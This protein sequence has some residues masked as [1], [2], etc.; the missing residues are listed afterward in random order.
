MNVR[1]QKLSNARHKQRHIATLD[2]SIMHDP[3]TLDHIQEVDAKRLPIVVSRNETRD[4][5]QEG[6]DTAATAVPSCPRTDG[7]AGALPA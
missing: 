7:A 6:A 2:E 5:F 3:V 1:A 4:T